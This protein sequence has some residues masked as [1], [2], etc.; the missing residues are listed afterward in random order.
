MSRFGGESFALEKSARFDL[1]E[2]NEKFS[3]LQLWPGVG[4]DGDGEMSGVSM[5][6]LSSFSQ[7]NCS[8]EAT[9]NPFKSNQK[10]LPAIESSPWIGF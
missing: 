6:E 10:P 1:C 3:Q 5:L 2:W 9:Q 7:S 4:L 8:I